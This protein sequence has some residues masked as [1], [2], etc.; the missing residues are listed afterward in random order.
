[1]RLPR[2]LDLLRMTIRVQGKWITAVR[3]LVGIEL[4]ALDMP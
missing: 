3:L 2:R 1:M 4:L